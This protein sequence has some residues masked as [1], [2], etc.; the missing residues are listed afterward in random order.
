M[1]TKCLNAKL[2]K[3]QLQFVDSGTNYTNLNLHY[4]WPGNMLFVSV[5]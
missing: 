2:E 4:F 5:W 1:Q 3:I